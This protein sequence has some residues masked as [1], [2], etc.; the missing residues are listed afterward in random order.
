[1][2]P[3]PSASLIQVTAAIEICNAAFP[4]I[5]VAKGPR[6][7]MVDMQSIL[8]LSDFADTYHPNAQGY[9]KMARAWESAILAMVPYLSVTSSCETPP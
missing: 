2:I 8:S 5:V 9:D 6:V 1:V 7:S 4:G 3:S